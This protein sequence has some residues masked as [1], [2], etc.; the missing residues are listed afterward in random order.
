M[1]EVVMHYVSDDTYWVMP[2]ST[3]ARLMRIETDSAFNRRLGS[4]TKVYKQYVCHVQ[5]GRLSFEAESLEEGMKWV[6]AQVVANRLTQ[7]N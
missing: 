6:E 4:V 1:D 7:T 2:N 3:T 5:F